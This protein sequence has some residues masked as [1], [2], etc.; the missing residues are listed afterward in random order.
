MVEP[1]LLIGEGLCELLA[2]SGTFDVVGKVLSV[3]DAYAFKPAPDLIMIDIDAMARDAVEAIRDCKAS[4]PIAHICVLTAFG[5]EE[6]MQ[7]CLAAG[8]DGFIVKDASKAEFLRA[9]RVIT[10]GDS[11]VDPR[12]AGTFLR[13][14]NGATWRSDPDE[15]SPREVEIVC[16]IANGLSNRDISARLELSEKTVK[17]YISRIF[18][19]LHV[20]ARTQAAAY[21]F[22]T[23]MV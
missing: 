7:R 6:V 14:R 2:R 11:Y 18:S 19:K 5:N 20:C 17:N 10:E 21:A 12:V 15:L 3:A 8:A 16:L 9:T 13:R 22:K 4:V 23:G 1:F